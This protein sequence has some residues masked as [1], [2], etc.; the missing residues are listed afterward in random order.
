MCFSFNYH[1]PL[2]NNQL[3]Y[4]LLLFL[5]SIQLKNR[6]TVQKVPSEWVAPWCSEQMFLGIVSLITLSSFVTYTQQSLLPFLS[7]CCN[8]IKNCSKNNQGMSR[9]VP[10]PFQ[11]IPLIL[12]AI[13][14]IRHTAVYVTAETLVV[15]LCLTPHLL[16]AL[17]LDFQGQLW[18][19][20]LLI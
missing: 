14:S 1:G 2:I 4:M 18:G 11:L 5:T 10:S 7:R 16:T 8:Q 20:R 6:W 19:W 15:P 13:R 17:L 3:D 9:A 12:T